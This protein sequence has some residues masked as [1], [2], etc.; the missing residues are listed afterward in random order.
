MMISGKIEYTKEDHTLYDSSAANSQNNTVL[1]V[2]LDLTEAYIN[3]WSKQPAVFTKTIPSR[4]W[5]RFLY[6][7]EYLL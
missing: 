7:G 1:T 2:E 6:D 3:N 4:V 5:L